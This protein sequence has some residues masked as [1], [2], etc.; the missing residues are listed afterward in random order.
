MTI[1]KFEK[2]RLKSFKLLDPYKNEGG[3]R[4]RLYNFINSNTLS[5]GNKRKHKRELIKV[6]DKHK[7]LLEEY[8]QAHVNCTCGAFDIN[9]LPTNPY[10]QANGKKDI[11]G[12]EF[13]IE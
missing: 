4:F 9:D 5:T 8:N 10:V 12:E 3:W 2:V 13:R 7:K 11:L 1:D 6:K